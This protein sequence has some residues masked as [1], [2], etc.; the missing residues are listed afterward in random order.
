MILTEQDYEEYDRYRQSLFSVLQANLLTGDVLVVG[1]SLRDL[2]LGKLVKDV[3]NHK[4]EGSPGQ[5][6]VLIYDRDDLR[7]P[8]LEDRGARVAFGGIDELVHAL[9]VGLESNVPE[10]SETENALPVAVV[11]TVNDANVFSNS[12]SPPV[13]HFIREVGLRFR[14]AAWN[15]LGSA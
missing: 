9:A 10:G 14:G 4:Q 8:L 12:K 11:S 2:H 5:V 13:T 15:Q 1:Q 6:Y 7:A 3:L